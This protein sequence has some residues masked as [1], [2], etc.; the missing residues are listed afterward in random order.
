MLMAVSLPEADKRLTRRGLA[1][2]HGAAPPAR[3]APRMTASPAAALT[4][5]DQACPA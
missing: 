2:G 5:I 1:L 3:Q 4:A